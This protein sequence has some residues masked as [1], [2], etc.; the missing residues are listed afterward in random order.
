MHA[1]PVW[2]LHLKPA[3]KPLQPTWLVGGPCGDAIGEALDNHTLAEAVILTRN[4]SNEWNKGV[5]ILK[6]LE[7]R[8]R[9]N[10]ERVLDI[11]LAEAI[12]IQFASAHNMLNFYLMRSRL[13]DLPPADALGLLAAM[14]AIVRQE[15]QNSQRL[16]VLCAA[17]SRLGF[18]CEAERH[19]YFGARLTWRVA[20]LNDLLATEFV[21]YRT[22]LQAGKPLSLFAEGR[23]VY[24]CGSGW[25]DC[26]TYRWQAQFDNDILTLRVEMKAP[27]RAGS[28]TAYFCDPF[29]TSHFWEI[30]FDTSGAVSDS[31]EIGLQAEPYTTPGGVHGVTLR[32]PSQGLL[33]LD[34]SARAY[35]FNL[36]NRGL[37][38]DNWPSGMDETDLGKYRLALGRFNPRK[39][40]YLRMPAAK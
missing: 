21:E 20:V 23:A 39:M 11:G 14:E 5:A 18:H 25:T 31:R 28:F 29:V 26:R 7:P 8:F 10:R 33:L 12:G 40:G 27:N 3:L 22:A 35:A 30:N 13:F 38:A 34:P 2:P 19:Q 24:T 36:F 37:V 4:M 1:T 16:D 9:G 17:D 15:I 6:S 32:V